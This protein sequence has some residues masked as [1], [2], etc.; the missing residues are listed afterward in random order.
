MKPNLAF[1]GGEDGLKFVR[2]ILIQAADYLSNQGYLL[3]E[4]GSNADALE[5]AYPGLSVS[6]ANQSK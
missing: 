2:Q 4:L 3:I 6:V 5:S 1:A